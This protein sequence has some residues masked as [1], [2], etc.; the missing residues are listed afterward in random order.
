[1]SGGIALIDYNNDG[2]MDIYITDSLTVDTAN[3]PR[4]SHSAL[5]K[6]LGNGKFV[7]VA[8]EAGV[9]HPGWAMGVCVADVDGDGWDDMYVTGLGR[10]FL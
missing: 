10:H 3:N 1:M 7:D 9:A 6:N 4:A 5:Y 8:E 2:L